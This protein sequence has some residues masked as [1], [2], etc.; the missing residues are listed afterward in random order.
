MDQVCHGYNTVRGPSTV[1]D[2]YMG[3]RLIGWF[4]EVTADGPK[5]PIL[6]SVSG[7][8]PDDNCIVGY[9]G[10]GSDGKRKWY[11]HWYRD[12]Q[13]YHVPET[14]FDSPEDALKAAAEFNER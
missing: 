7:L 11:L 8:S 5:E 6:Y 9:A 13:R 10:I 4:R 1:S 14:P 2:T 3:L 12:G